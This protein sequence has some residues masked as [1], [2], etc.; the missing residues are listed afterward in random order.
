[1]GWGS[2]ENAEEVGSVGQRFDACGRV[3]LH[4]VVWLRE[5]ACRKRGE[6]RGEREAGGEERR[7]KV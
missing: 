3:V 6:K 2:K 5:V 7:G 1:L 4:S